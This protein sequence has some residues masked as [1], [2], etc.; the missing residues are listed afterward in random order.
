MTP[1]I[2]AFTL[3]AASGAPR[4]VVTG[5]PLEAILGELTRG[6]AEVDNLLP[7]GASPH[8][9]EPVP[10]DLRRAESATALFFVSPSLDGWAARLPARD[11]I[12][13]LA[14]VPRDARL[15]DLEVHETH[16][17]ETEAG[18]DP[19]FWTDPL[20]VKAV[21]PGLVEQLCRL[22]PAGADLYRRNG[23]H[24]TEQLDV[25]HAE[26]SRRL[27]PLAGR[28]V[29]LFHPSF[30]Y[31]IHRYG[32]ELAGVVEPS[33]GK[34]P[35]PRRLEHIVQLV[36]RRGVKAV[37]GEPQLPRRAAENVAEAAGVKLFLLDPMGGVPGRLTYAEL[38][39]YNAR[40][41]VEA[42]Q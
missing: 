23:A 17:G 16:A 41:L 3:G 9:Y 22:D 20:L 36:R 25:L 14:L 11:K 13:V 33:P 19:H 8:T 1:A 42:L 32:L 27:A 7:A 28:P 10:S 12:E 18:G 39:N 35:T 6:R 2:F 24:F 31:L 29:V 5:H 40:V 37:F 34:E 30:Q 4:Y 26:I 38:L 21:V 15:P